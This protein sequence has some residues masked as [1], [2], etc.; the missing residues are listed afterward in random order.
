MSCAT[1]NDKPFWLQLF[2]A[3][4]RRVYRKKEERPSKPEQA[5]PEEGKL[6]VSPGAT[7]SALGGSILGLLH[8]GGLGSSV[9]MSSWDVI[10]SRST[11]RVGLAEVPTRATSQ[12]DT[13]DVIS[14][15]SPSQASAWD[16][17][18][19]PVSRVDPLDYET[20]CDS[21]HS[22]TPNPTSPSSDH[23]ARQP[24]QLDPTNLKSSLRYILKFA[25]NEI[26]KKRRKL[27]SSLLESS[28][29]RQL[30]KR[31]S[32]IAPP[33]VV[34]LKDL[35]DDFQDA[36]SPLSTDRDYF[37][38]EPFHPE[39]EVEQV[40]RLLSQSL[41]CTS[42]IEVAVISVDGVILPSYNSA[43]GKQGQC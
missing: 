26:Q 7:V 8:V 9:S 13:W 41:H 3:G 10:G 32:S 24:I 12:L 20:A 23:P 43:E 37:V 5:A 36:T 33:P 4:H 25:G 18:S 42:N 1:L 22:K 31:R 28:T 39:E 17:I 19:R 2:P 29:S 40:R 35:A 14:T 34:L 11:S 27:K 21:S 30:K 15:R 38:E 16:M 6:S